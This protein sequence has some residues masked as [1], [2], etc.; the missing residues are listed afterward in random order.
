MIFSQV[1]YQA[2]L[3]RLK[4]ATAGIEPAMRVLQTLALPLG[5]VANMAER[6]GFEPPT[7]LRPQRLSRPL[8]YRAMVTS[9]RSVD[10]R[11]LSRRVSR[12][13]PARLG[14]WRDAGRG[15][16]IRTPTY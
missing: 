4:E 16:G 8:H 13:V 15:T 1:L 11:L 7:G 2:E 5:D 14:A 6:G 12:P 10:L 9:P 3:P